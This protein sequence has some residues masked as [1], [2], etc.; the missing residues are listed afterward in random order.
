MSEQINSALELIRKEGLIVVALASLIWQVYWLTTNYSAADLLWR[1]EIKAYRMAAEDR[2]QK[3]LEASA[4]IAQ[5]M[6]RMAERLERIEKAL[7]EAES[8]LETV[9]HEIDNP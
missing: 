5:V 3:R 6:T 2:A 9:E 1:E 7:L 4:E 8:E